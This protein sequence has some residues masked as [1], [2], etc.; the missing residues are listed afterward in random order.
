MANL[1]KTINYI[2]FPLKNAD[3]TKAFYTRVFHWSF[4]DWG[5]KYI[6][7]TGA[8]VE[9]GFN[10]EADTPVTAPGVLVVLYADDLEAILIE[11]KSAGGLILRTPYDFPGGRRFHFS[12]PNGNE[13]AVWTEAKQ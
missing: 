10:G 4:Q 11:V 5:D 13:L 9:G 3:R 7:F 8:G 6:S 2:E 12:D 1:D